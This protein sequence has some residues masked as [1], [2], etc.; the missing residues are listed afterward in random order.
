MKHLYFIRHGESE[1]NRAGKFAGTSDPPLTDTGHEQAKQAAQELQSKG[2]SFDIIISSP[3]QRAHH[4]AKYVA[5]ATNY[6]HDQI[7]L[8]PIF[9]ERH[10]GKLEGVNADSILGA[11][12]YL[13]ESIIDDHEEVETLEDFQ[14]RANAALEYLHSLDHQTILLVAHGALGRA[15]YRAVNDLPITERDIRYRNA[16]VVKFI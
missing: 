9:Q 6:P 4:T 14:K 13:N 16:E 12:H 1:F 11:Q 8:N 3:L 2:L 10:Y 7:E 15:L 5:T